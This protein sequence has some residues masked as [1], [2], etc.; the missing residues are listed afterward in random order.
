MTSNI[1]SYLQA[2]TVDIQ[3]I[4]I[5][6]IEPLINRSDPQKVAD[7]IGAVCEEI[8]FLYIKNH[9]IKK[10]LMEKINKYS[11]EFFSLPL[12]EKNKINIINSGAA[13]R[14]YIPMYGENVDPSYTKDIQGMF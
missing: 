6:D 11:Q 9:G 1:H 13:L 8:G 10:D 4:P 3:Q 2:S 12:E 14:G 5:I 7:Q